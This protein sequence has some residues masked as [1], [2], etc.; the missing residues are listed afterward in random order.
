MS[1][2][3]YLEGA[4]GRLKLKKMELET[5]ISANIKAA[6][7]LLEGSGI[8]PISKIDIEGALVNLKEA[9]ALKDKHSEVVA[10]IAK[11]NAEI[12]ELS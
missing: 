8:K 12:E 5:S 1:E 3:L 4:L 2:K 11:I 9:K 6:K 10:E 7:R